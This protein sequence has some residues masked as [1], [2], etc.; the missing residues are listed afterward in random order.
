MSITETTSVRDL[1]KIVWSLVRDVLSGN[2]ER[3][4]LELNEAAKKQK[5][6]FGLNDV[7]RM[8]NSGRGTTLLVEEDY[9]VKGSIMKTD[10]SLIIFKNV[11]IMEVFDD[12][13][14]INRYPEKS[15]FRSFPKLYRL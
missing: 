1:G 11:D 14:S 10:N 9:H 13:L 3:V 12:A 15:L 8:I 6:A 4:L 5:V 7:C 2:H